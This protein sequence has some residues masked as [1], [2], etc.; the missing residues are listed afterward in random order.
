CNSVTPKGKLSYT[1][2]AWSLRTLLHK[3]PV[4]HFSCLSLDTM[5]RIICVLAVIWQVFAKV[6]S[7]EER[8]EI[9]ANLTQIRGNVT[10][11]ASNM[12][13]LTYSETLE[14]VAN[15]YVLK[16][17]PEYPWDYIYQEY[18]GIGFIFSKYSGQP[19]FKDAIS[20][21]NNS[22]SYDYDKDLCRGACKDY[23]QAVTAAATA[24]GCAKQYCKNHGLGL[25]ACA[26]NNS[27]N[28]RRGWPYVR[29]TSCSKCPMDDCIHKQCSAKSPPSPENETTTSSS[30]SST[31]TTPASATPDT[32]TPASATPDTTTPASTTTAST[33]TSTTDTA[34]GLSS[35]TIE[36]MNTVSST[37]QQQSV[38][39]TSG[40]TTILI[41]ASLHLSIFFLYF[42]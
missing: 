29:G 20:L 41:F 35:T 25:V 39:T 30:T 17:I 14:R 38:K 3:L 8:A 1:P 37:S 36:T 27:D 22:A 24:V 7:K 16:C 13:L 10:P 33:T 32:T 6:P 26:F 40:S 5:R 23:K 34:E 19:H 4:K 12:N 21:A 2:H 42:L 9:L 15:R 28:R 31:S 18:V 11:E